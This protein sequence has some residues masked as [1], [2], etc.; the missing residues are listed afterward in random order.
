MHI[1]LLFLRQVGVEKCT[2]DTILVKFEVVSDPQG[3]Q[4]YDGSREGHGRK[5][6]LVVDPITL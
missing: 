5:S 4:L 6:L 2:F 1:P 3:E